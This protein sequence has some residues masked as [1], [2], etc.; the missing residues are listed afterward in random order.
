[1]ADLLA[2]KRAGL[3]RVVWNMLEKP[4]RVPPAAQVAGAGTQG[5][6]VPPGSYTVRVTNNGQTY[7]SPLR[8]SLDPSAT[9]TVAE[10]QAQYAAAVRVKKLFGAESN[11]MERIVKLRSDLAEAGAG[12]AKNGPPS[13][14]LAQFDAKVDAVRKQIVATTEGGAI[15]GE[16]RLREHTD[17]LYGAVLTNEGKP[18]EYQQ[19]NIIAL[20]AELR[21]IQHD[22]EALTAQDL[23][24]LNRQL[25][26][27]GIG[28]IKV[29]PESE[30]DEDENEASA[31]PHAGNDDHDALMERRNI[32][33]NFRP[34]H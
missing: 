17:Q 32:P 21:R 2:S 29:K 26:G 20:D 31:N 12:L 15:T 25:S 22:F 10:R 6:R 1:V 5:P 16:E 23:P 24:S 4:P 9:F 33:T 30:A 11:L 7:E 18:A 14:T 27:A 28:P 13:R 3:N 19:D 34:L 8:V